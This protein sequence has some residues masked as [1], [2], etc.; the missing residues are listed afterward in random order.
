MNKQLLEIRQACEQSLYQFAMV[1][2]PDRYY[3]DVH[4][5][6]FN[7]LQ[8]EEGAPYRLGLIPRDHQKSHC[9]VV[10]CAWRLCVNPEWTFV[11]VSANPELAGDQLNSI[12]NVL[13]TPQIRELFPELLRYTKDKRTGELKRKPKYRDT[14][15]LFSVDHPVREEKQI[16]DPSIRA[17]SVK[18]SKTGF[19]CKEVIFDDLVTDEN[20]ESEADR[21]EVLKTYKNLMK[22]AT[23]DSLSKAVGTRYSSQDLYEEMLNSFYEDWENVDEDG[24]PK[25]EPMWEVFERV[26]EDSP[27]RTGEGT[28]IFP[29]IVTEDGSV[30]GFD[31]TEL[32]K[33]RSAL[34]VGGDTSS[35][36]AQYYNDANDSTNEQFDRSTFRYIDPKSLINEEGKWYYCDRR[37]SII[38]AAD[39][40]WTEGGAKGGK[41]ADYTAIA[42]VGICTD[43][44]TYVLDHDRF[45]TDKPDIYFSKIIAL[46]EK[47]KF[48]EIIV[49]TNSGGKFI[50]RDLEDLVRQNGSSLIVKG[51]THAGGGSAKKEERISQVL[52]HRYANQ[53]VFHYIGGYIGLYEDELVMA[54]PPHDDLKD[55]TALA[56]SECKKPIS[57]TIVKHKPKNVVQLSRFGGRRRA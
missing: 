22:I 8:R 1:A 16:R 42:V 43:G 57:A 32:S 7:F 25:L 20:Y 17:T 18:S 24:N 48:R 5:E 44:Y 51:K 31:R 49:E 35:F 15:E 54:R 29:K 23:T 39:L 4:K 28:F 26:V 53:N 19:H 40:A 37:L 50:K 9:M 52:H 46:H 2:F 38:A 3:A 55:A 12:R 47:W 41:R 13:C 30:F 45:K 14:N 56:V 10:Y 21:R 36:Y 34:S 6:F 33:K 27:R 11:Y